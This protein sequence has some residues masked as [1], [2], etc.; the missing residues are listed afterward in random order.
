MNEIDT[1]PKSLISAY[2]K[3][4]DGKT[5]MRQKDM[6]LWRSFTWEESYRQV[7]KL[8]LGLI[9]LGL[10]E[11]RRQNLYHRRQRSAVLLG[12]TGDPGWRWSGSGHLHR[13]LT[14]RG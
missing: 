9:M 6:G 10:K 7:R 5:A 4:G 1:L 14:S 11:K 8:S 3:Y 12:S 13:Q 2:K